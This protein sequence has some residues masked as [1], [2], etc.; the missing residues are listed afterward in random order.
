MDRIGRGSV[1]VD[2]CCVSMLGGIQPARL[3]SY[4]ADA[5]QDGPQNDGL[6]QRFQVLIYP[7]VPQGW[8][9]VDR[10][11]NSAAIAGAEAL[12]HRL[13]HLDAAEPL[14]FHFAADAQELFIAWLTD[15]EGKVRC[16]DLHPALVA[17]VAKYRSL[18]PSLALLF[19]LA[20]DGT[21]TVLIQHAQQAAAWCDYLESHAERIYSML[22]SPE[23]QAAAE[24]GRHLKA[25]WKRQD[26]MFTVRDVY[27]NNWRGLTTPED[28]RRALPL[29]Q[30][31]GWV[32]R[33]EVE[34]GKGRPTELYAINPK[35]ARGKK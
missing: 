2:A 28:V 17:H 22:I 4:L 18:M 16:D 11:P 3:R 32:R 25:G 13:A 20:D 9:Y 6:F 8:Q 5:L 24:L 29:L 23:R 10:P 27:Q 26:G 35:L 7:D 21:E 30:D 15:L 19:E 14:R 12:Y 34:Q 31:A 1:H 33:V